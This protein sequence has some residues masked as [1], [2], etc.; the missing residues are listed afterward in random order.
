M[1][2]NNLD[3][4]SSVLSL[5]ALCSDIVELR[6]HGAVFW[7]FRPRNKQC[8]SV[9]RYVLKKNGI[10]SE[11]YKSKYYDMYSKPVFVFR[12]SK[13]AFDEASSDFKTKF[14]NMYSWREDNRVETMNS[15]H[16]NGWFSLMSASKKVALIKSA[17]D[18]VAK[19]VNQIER[20]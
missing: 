8:R 9:V 6:R 11:G 18:I 19:K 4:D 2:K 17:A 10:E 16:V 14:Q 7:Y 15:V 12:C 1:K 13:L 5:Y 3:V 20:S